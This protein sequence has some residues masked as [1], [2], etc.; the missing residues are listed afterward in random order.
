MLNDKI[1]NK[2]EETLKTIQEVSDIVDEKYQY[3]DI[4]GIGAEFEGIANDAHNI[5]ISL[6]VRALGL[7]QRIEKL[8]D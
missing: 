6:K 5:L 3:G 7:K 2:F 1:V 4:N 8:N